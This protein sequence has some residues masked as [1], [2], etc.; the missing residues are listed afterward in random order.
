MFNGGISP[1]PLPVLAWRSQHACLR[2]APEAAVCWA[3]R[4]IW[5]HGVWRVWTV[6]PPAGAN[7]AS[8]RTSDSVLFVF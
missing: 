7:A 4:L 3:P 8:F 6:F 5:F 1:K 2:L